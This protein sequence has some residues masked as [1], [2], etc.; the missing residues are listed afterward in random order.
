MGLGMAEKDPDDI[1]WDLKVLDMLVPVLLS[2]GADYTEK[3]YNEKGEGKGRMLGDLSGV[4][5]EQWTMKALAVEFKIRY[6]GGASKR[7]IRTLGVYRQY[8]IR[9]CKECHNLL[10]TY[11]GHHDCVGYVHPLHQGRPGGRLRGGLRACKGGLPVLQIETQRRAP[12]H[13][14]LLQDVPTDPVHP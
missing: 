7:N 8:K 4:D 14:G 10:R 11:D 1:D 12:D 9:V 3:D 2:P 5:W 13:R 6:W